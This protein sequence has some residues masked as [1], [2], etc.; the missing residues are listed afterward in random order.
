MCAPETQI[1]INKRDRRQT[2]INCQILKIKGCLLKYRIRKLT[3]ERQK[4]VM[5]YLSKKG[6]K[7]V[8]LT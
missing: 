8:Q 5:K 4:G 3:T 7:Y 2:V 1:K 6:I